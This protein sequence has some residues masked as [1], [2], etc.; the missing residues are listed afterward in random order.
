MRVTVEKIL[1]DEIIQPIKAWG[2]A[3]GKGIKEAKEDI[4]TVRKGGK[5]VSAE[6]EDDQLQN[7]RSV[8]FVFS[9]E[10]EIRVSDTRKAIMFKLR[11]LVNDAL[12]N[13]HTHLAADIL[14][15]YN[16]Y[17]ECQDSFC[18]PTG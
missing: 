7:L 8:G 14:S 15:V 16:K 17:V 10:G 3:T 5:P 2:M 6:I 13:E 11:L 12:D 1:N 4:D 9:D 18:M